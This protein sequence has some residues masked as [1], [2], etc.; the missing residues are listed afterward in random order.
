MDHSYTNFGIY[1]TARDVFRPNFRLSVESGARFIR[2]FQWNDKHT[3]FSDWNFRIRRILILLLLPS[4]C[5]SFIFWF[6]NFG[7][8]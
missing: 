5:I 2:R 7:K 6:E 8:F 4:N 3:I 1:F